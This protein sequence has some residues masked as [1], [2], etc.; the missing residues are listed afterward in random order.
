[1]RIRAAG[2]WRRAAVAIFGIAALGCALAW[3][4]GPRLLSAAE[5]SDA[6]FLVENEAALDSEQLLIQR[7]ALR[8]KQ[9]PPAPAPPIVDAPTFNPIDQFI[10]AQWA[11]AP[12]KV[13]PQLCDDA[14]FLRRVYLDLVGV[15]PLPAEANRFL[16]SG[17][18]QAKRE[19]LVDQLLAR[20]SDYAAHW[21]PF[22]E[23]ALASQNVLAQGGILTRGNY[24]DWIVQSFENNRP[25]DVMVAELLDPTMPGRRGPQ[26][27][28]VLGSKFTI[29]Y[30]RNEDHT[31]SL[32]TAANV[33]QVF[34][35]TGMKCA[36]CHD[37]F[38][39]SE[40]PQD[41][42]LAFAGLLSPHDLEHV[43]CELKSG[44]TVPA[45]FPF[46]LPGAPQS[47][48][49]DLRGRLHLAAQLI[50]D[51]A[52]P[53]FAKTIVNRLWK[54]YFGLGLFE[55]A[56][57]FRLDLPPSHPELLDWLAYDFLEHGCDLKHTIRLLLTSRTY[58]LRYD[59][60]LE[61]HFGA[62]QQNAPRY[63]RSPS[64]RRLTAEQLLDS[65]R[66]AASGQF[67][68]AERCF[69]DARS[70]A[71][72]RALGRP[73]SRNE[74]STSRPDDAAVVQALELLNGREL[75]EMIYS[76]TLFTEAA[77]RQDP[78]R[79]VDR[80]YR[81]ALSRPA[82]VPEKNAG[83]AFLQSAESPAEGMKDLLWALVCSPEFQYLK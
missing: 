13:E 37:H 49:D 31:A 57:D 73:A 55:P 25:Y 32:Q 26:T 4:T 74:I 61:D 23:D 36:S 17:A 46:D 43:R 3:P 44:K 62:G 1:M 45:R 2:T 29:E 58:Q 41:R 68:P 11:K 67:V 24:R 47:V 30:V 22:W 53:R 39:N 77:S 51:P 48:P 60:R 65:V 54:R 38:E 5:E 76:N 59:P 34:L 79:L 78:R 27:E 64:L 33:G 52:N 75:H 8:L 66:V 15:I 70:T 42:F 80:L 19:K 12:G 82:N 20:T 72:A 18:P 9:L 14:T 83:R 21:T 28:D 16:A 40:W 10:A 71:L 56:D 63:F 69:L 50:T 35:G 81:A 7:R 6:P